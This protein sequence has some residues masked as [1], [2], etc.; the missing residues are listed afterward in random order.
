MN[1][2][3]Y[4]D[5]KKN[6][7]E[8]LRDESQLLLKSNLN[9]IQTI[10]SQIKHMTEEEENPSKFFLPETAENYEKEIVELQDKINTLELEDASLSEK[11]AYCEE[12]LHLLDTLELPDFEL[13]E[14]NMAWTPMVVSEEEF[15]KRNVSRETILSDGEK[16]NVSR[17]TIDPLQAEASFADGFDETVGEI[18]DLEHLILNVSRETFSDGESDDLS[19]DDSNEIAAE[20]SIPELNH[21]KEKILFCRQISELDPHR[22]SLLLDEIINEI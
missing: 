5:K 21:I 1:I 7:Y 3:E 17:E 8:T 19:T 14:K 18:K 22:C 9:R 6:E 13:A 15:Q 20:A 11:I 10:S 12:E 2:F 4:I 16:V